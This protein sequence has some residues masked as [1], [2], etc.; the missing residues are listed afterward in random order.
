MANQGRGL[1]A[2]GLAL[3]GALPLGG[4]QAFQVRSGDWTTSLDTTLAYGLSYRVEGQDSKLIARANGGTGDN[5]GLINSDDGDLNFRRGDLFSEVVKA[6]SELDL[7]YQDRF[8]VFVRGRAFYDFELKDDERRHRQISHAGLD[9]AG[10]SADLLDAFVY[11]S[12]TVNDRALNARLGRQVINWG[13]GLFYQNGIG[14]TN[15]VDINALRAPGSEVKEAYMPTF[16][17]YASFE[18]RDNLSVEGYWQPGKAW[19]AS[20]IDPCGTYYSTLDVIGEGCNYLSVSPLQEAVAGG[21]AFDNPALA[22]AYA[23]A[24]APGGLNNLLKAYLPTTF[25]PRAQDI[26]G[27]D[28]AQYGLALRWYVPELNDTEL[29]FYYLRYNMQVPMLGLTVGQPVT[30]PI[31]G[32]LPNASSSRY[33]AEYLEK[34]D[35]FG[36]S[37]NTSIGGESIFNGLSLA[38]ELSYRPDTPI[39]LGLNEYLPDALFN[40]NGLP[41]GTHL[42][43]YREKDMYQASLAA[44]YNFTGVLG[45]DS[46]TLFT[47]LVASRVQGLESDID[48][49]EATSTATGAQASLQLTYTNVFNLVNLVPSFG[50]QYSING[51]AP[52]LTNGLDEEA[53]SWSAGIDAIYKESFTVGTRYVGYSGGGVSNKRSDRDFVSFN[54]KYSF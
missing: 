5:A 16:M 54:I 22:Q 8:G 21:R 9:E 25:I 18:L 41:V 43:G 3:L 19:E 2:A 48:Y 24:L 7:R 47:E 31:V 36:I 17:A 52:Q 38:G 29:G 50:Y 40:P 53:Q 4:A 39:A 11:G 37:F 44:I 13:E 46:A 23:D 33:Y 49:Y 45:A 27:D 26:D 51:V 14:A 20:K 34:R 6:V 42:D 12:W 28:A 1:A 30:L 32:T 35:L 15:P 10:S